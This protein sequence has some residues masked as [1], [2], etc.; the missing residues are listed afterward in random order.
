MKLQSP[1]KVFSLLLTLVLLQSCKEYDGEACA[2]LYVK[3]YRGH[4]R[5]AN[6][7][8]KECVSRKLTPKFNCQT[9]LEELIMGR[10]DVYLKAKYGS[11]VM[12]CFTEKDLR[13]FLK[14]TPKT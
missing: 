2:D 8:E 10:D 3:A 14:P 11:H 13:L 7:Y 1:I 12:K 9:A 4:P 5:S 6:E